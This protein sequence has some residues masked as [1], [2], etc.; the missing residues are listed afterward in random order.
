MWPVCSFPLALC[1]VGK[2]LLHCGEPWPSCQHFWCIMTRHSHTI[3][4]LLCIC[5]GVCVW[6]CGGGCICVCVCV[7]V[8][9]CVWVWIEYMTKQL[10]ILRVLNL[11][12]MRQDAWG[13]SH[14]L[15]LSLSLQSPPLFRS[16]SFVI[17]L[18]SSISTYYINTEQW[19]VTWKTDHNL[20]KDPLSISS[21]INVQT[22]FIYFGFYWMIVN[23]QAHIW[24]YTIYW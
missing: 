8:G 10:G 20:C 3:A 19:D 23:W 16:F 4:D 17:S 24:L 22:L 14:F 1:N 9:V 15:S 5:V 2:K 6:V 7:C 18:C 11:W 21:L 13:K 12:F